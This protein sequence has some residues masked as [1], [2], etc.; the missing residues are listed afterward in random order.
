[1]VV[2]AQV[3]DGPV[4]QGHA[5]LPVRQMAANARASA[6]MPQSASTILAPGSRFF[7]RRSSRTSASMAR[8]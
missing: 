2:F 6:V 8:A 4:R 7:S 3:D 5:L 1:M